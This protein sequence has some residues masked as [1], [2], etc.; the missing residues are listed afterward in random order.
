MDYEE[1]KRYVEVSIAHSITVDVRAVPDAPGNVRTTTIHS[2][3]RVTI[4]FQKCSE[5]V[6]GDFEGGGLKYVGQY[7]TLDDA[8]RALEKYLASPV[9]QWRNYTRERF[10]PVLLAEP[11]SA[12]N[13]AYFERIVRERRIS[14]PGRGRFR[15]AGVHWRHVERYGEYRGDKLIEEQE[16]T[17]RER[18]IESESDGS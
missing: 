17:L 18:D 13:L 12:A 3:Y 4:E 16:L 14:L 2:D 9:R 5:Y 1:L 8:V 7:E 10:E 6:S 11:D 15:L